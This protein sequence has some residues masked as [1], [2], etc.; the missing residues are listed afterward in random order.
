VTDYPSNI[1]QALID[2]EIDLGLVPVAIIP[3]LKE[4]HIVTDYCIG[5]DGEVASVALFS[6]APLT[7]IEN[8]LMDYQSRTSVALSRILMDKF[9]KIQPVIQNGNA[10]FQQQIRGKTAGVIIGD[11]ALE[12]RKV[13]PYVYD[14]GKAWKDFTGLPFVFAAWISNKK[15]PAA[16]VEEFNEANA[17]GLQNLDAV[18]ARISSPNIDLRTYYTRYI[19][20]S[21]NRAKM[22]GM[23]QFLALLEER[24]FTQDNVRFK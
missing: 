22:Q 5:C 20:F 24:T 16:F 7:S 12:Q 6:S 2:D 9:W 19:D 10:H 4:H 17:W 11:R 14:L 23:E 8:V 3:L 13:S 18:L 21:L 15:L 1:A